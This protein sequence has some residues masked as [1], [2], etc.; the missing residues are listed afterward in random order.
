MA[1]FSVLITAC[2]L[3]SSAKIVTNFFI[4]S[5]KSLIYILE[6]ILALTPLPGVYRVLPQ[7]TAIPLLELLLFVFF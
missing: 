7:P 5:G 3:V 2:S 4:A 6:I 1:S